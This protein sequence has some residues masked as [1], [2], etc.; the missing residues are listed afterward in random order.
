MA[1]R[2]GVEV[3]WV[4]TAAVIFILI[5]SG[6]VPKD[7]FTWF[8]EVTPIL[9]GLPALL[10]LAGRGVPVTP[11]LLVLMGVHAA[12]LAMGGKYTTGYVFGFGGKCL[13]PSPVVGN[14]FAPIVEA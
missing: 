14:S 6:V 1:K 10:F 3:I 5:W 11:L 8:L 9:I 12:I 2:A 4:V 7:R 13:R